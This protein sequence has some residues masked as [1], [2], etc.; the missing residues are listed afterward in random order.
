[1]QLR[2]HTHDQP[3]ASTQT[4]ST[5]CVLLAQMDLPPSPLPAVAGLSF[6]V[7]QVWD[8]LASRRLLVIL[9]ALIVCALP[10]SSSH[11]TLLWIAP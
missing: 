2:Y 11:G 6:K 10:E 8:S 3:S 5:M 4:Q 7:T 9:Y 1:M